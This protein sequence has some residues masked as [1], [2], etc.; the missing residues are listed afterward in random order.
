MEYKDLVH[1]LLSVSV[2]HR[3]RI[4]KDAQ[5]NGLYFGQPV[6]LEYILNNNLC[7]QKELA[8]SLHISPPSAATSLKRME[9]TGLIDRVADKEDVRKN[10]L[11]LTEK[12]R[13]ALESFRETCK[14]TDE[15]MFKGFSRE[16]CEILEDFLTRLYKNLE[17]EEIAKEMK[18]VLPI[19]KE[20]N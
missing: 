2:I 4:S 20:V 10:R 12:G 19:H 18:N 6:I 14:S 7:T 17:T 5:K 9:K 16:E 8:G 1:S 13:E 3:Y 11:S 15:K